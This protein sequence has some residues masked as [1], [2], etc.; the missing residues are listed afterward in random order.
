MHVDVC[1][2]ILPTLIYVLRIIRHLRKNRKTATPDLLSFRAGRRGPYLRLLYHAA[3]YPG[4]CL[5][6]ILRASKPDP[7]ADWVQTC[8]PQIASL[9]LSEKQVRVLLAMRRLY[10]QNMGALERRRE[11]LAALVMP[12]R[13]RRPDPNCHLNPEP[14]PSSRFV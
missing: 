13:D 12:V 8:C 3:Q 9:H 2:R 14:R 6:L 1:D 5:G 11:E 7:T 10:L 4:M